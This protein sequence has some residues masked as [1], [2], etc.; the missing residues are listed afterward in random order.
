M[1]ISFSVYH[2]FVFILSCQYNCHYANLLS[3]HDV[4]KLTSRGHINESHSSAHHEWVSEWVVKRNMNAM[5]TLEKYSFNIDWLYWCWLCGI[6]W[7]CCALLHLLFP[8]SNPIFERQLFLSPRLLSITNLLK[9]Y[10]HF[11]LG[12][13]IRTFDSSLFDVCVFCV[14]RYLFGVFITGSHTIGIE[15]FACIP[16]H[17]SPLCPVSAFMINA[18]FHLCNVALTARYRKK[19]DSS[20]EPINIYVC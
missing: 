14:L 20:P 2:L 10:T 15:T 8:L 4:L 5:Q 6:C 17:Y 3:R 7:R 16:K 1:N 19:D 13:H 18:T 11:Y 9:F 12:S